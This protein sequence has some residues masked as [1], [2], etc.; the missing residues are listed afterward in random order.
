MIVVVIVGISAAL[1]APA[2]MRA[3][4]INR[5]NRCQYDAARMFRSARASAIGTGRAHLVHMTPTSGDV[6]LDVYIGD[7]SS[8]ARSGWTQ[9]VGGA[10]A[11]V[12]RLWETDYTAG[13]HG[14]GLTFR[15][16][17][18]GP[19]PQQ[20]CFEPQG[21]RLTRTGTTGQFTRAATTVLFVITRLENGSN[22]GDPERQILL[23]QFGTPRVLR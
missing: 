23:P 21:D 20:V 14:V 4:A 6:R 17:G 12:D 22:T 10:M 2:M 7:S 8:C 19:A 3:M 16:V 15:N 18:G 5:T 11:P 13:G 9:I 1:V